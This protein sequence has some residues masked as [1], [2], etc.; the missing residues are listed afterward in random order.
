MHHRY[1]D[2][3]KDPYGVNK[4]FWFAHIGWVLWK[5]DKS[6]IGR[7][8]V[9][10]LRSNRILAFQCRY[11]WQ[12]L[13]SLTV[14]LPVATCGLLWQDWTG[15]LVYATLLRVTLTLQSTFCVNSLAHW[16]GDQPFDDHHTPRDHLATALIT[17]GEGYHN[18][19]HEFPSD[20]RNAIE[21][22]QYDP[23]KWS[24]S[25]WE[26]LGLAS[27]LKHFRANEIEKGRLQQRKKQLD[28]QSLNIDWGVR[29]ELLPIM[30]W[31]DYVEQ[32]EG[33]RCLVVIAGIV[34]DIAGF[35][36][37]GHPG[38]E[39][40]IRLA[41]GKD[42]TAMFNGGVYAH[43]NAAH[44]LLATMRVGIIR[45]GMDVEIWKR[46]RTE[47]D[48]IRLEGAGTQ[49]T[50]ASVSKVDERAS[51]KLADRAVVS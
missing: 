43:S 33:G 21:W 47:P 27:N 3:E 36:A 9:D 41:I 18:F 24:I 23:T 50:R 15:G 44:N 17:L 40:I 7:T 38:G 10:D 25:L 8:N 14:L 22:Y 20:Y 45:G 32:A 19:H 34:H 49:I 1:T 37:E 4:G 13:L 42:A 48:G 31:A 51:S 12:L 35:L 2:T 6:T 11:Y 28:L 46:V 29:L 5:R 30:D 39:A 26:R 16:F